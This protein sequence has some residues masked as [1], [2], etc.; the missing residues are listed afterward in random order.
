MPDWSVAPLLPA[1]LPQLQQTH[2]NLFR[3]IWSTFHHIPPRD[4][5][6]SRDISDPAS[7]AIADSSCSPQ[8]VA[9]AVLCT[10]YCST[11][12][13]GAHQAACVRATTS[14]QGHGRGASCIDP[15][16]MC[17]VLQNLIKNWSWTLNC[18]FADPIFTSDKWMYGG[19]EYEPGGCIPPRPF[20]KLR[21]DCQDTNSRCE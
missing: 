4:V 13:V 19:I 2:L 21:L 3:L 9:L 15:R 20:F 11:A 7:V 1:L 18:W 14:R 6:S 5:S 17:S 16:S 10:T 12:S 8:Q